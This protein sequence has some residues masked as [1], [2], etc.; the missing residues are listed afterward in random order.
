MK[1]LNKIMAFILICVSIY[2]CKKNEIALTE[3]TLPTDKAFVRFAFFSPTTTTNNVMIKANDQKINGTFTNMNNGFFPSTL[4][5]ND[6]CAVPPSSNFRLSLPN[7][8]TL[9]D[10]IVLF[11]GNFGGVVAN[12]F[13]TLILADT[14]VNRTGFRVSDDAA[15]Y[16]DS[17]FIN[18]RFISAVPNAPLMII[19]ID[20]A[21]ATNV[22]RDTISRNLPFKE[23]T[24]FI[25]QSLQSRVTPAAVIRYRAVTLAS[26]IIPAG[27]II[28]TTAPTLNNRRAATIFATGFAGGVTPWTSNFG[29]LM[30]NK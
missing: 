22:V 30:T 9:N 4:T 15:S 2:A 28:G 16:A 7:T 18:L 17:G 26:G 27:V 6:Y 5:N 21:S 10:S 3:Y 11:T 24:S 12:T 19:R 25:T 29:N 1:F 8:S 23:A 13:S 20:S 14:G